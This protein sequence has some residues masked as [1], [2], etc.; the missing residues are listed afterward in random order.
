MNKL[1]DNVQPLDLISAVND[2]VEEVS[3]VPTN[4]SDLVDDTATTPIN[5]AT[6]AIKLG[7]SDVG[8]EIQPLYLSS[9][10]P[11]ACTYTLAKSVPSDAVFTDT[12]YNVFTG[13]DG[14]DAGSIGL[15]PAPLATD[16]NKFL[17]GDGTWTYAT[18]SGG[19]DIDLSNLTAT[20]EAHFLKSINSTDV[21]NA[22]GYTPQN[23]L[24]AVTHTAS[25]AVGSSTKPIYISSTGAATASSSTVGSSSTP[26]YLNAGTITST[27][28]SIASSRFDGQWVQSY[29]GSLVTATSKGSSQA[30]ISTYL[31]SDSYDYEVMFY[32]TSNYDSSAGD[33]AIGNIA[34]PLSNDCIRIKGRVRNTAASVYCTGIIPIK[35]SA[36]IIYTQREVKVSAFQVDMIAYRRIGTNT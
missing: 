22:L 35:S 30:S 32:L 11:T 20:G 23:S 33:V 34:S 8:G 12:T 9:G 6:M 29:H 15:V 18:G 21:T 26:V 28:L 36:R 7:S 13:A 27:G 4:L 24:T 25:T 16:N 2:L 17:K 5:K 19:A 10:E 3:N 1:T 31:P 14:T